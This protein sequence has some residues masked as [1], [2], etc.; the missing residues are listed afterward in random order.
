MKH[1]RLLLLCISM[2]LCAVSFQAFAAE[3]NPSFSIQKVIF[4][5]DGQM[6]LIVYVPPARE[7]TSSRL[8]LTLDGHPVSVSSIDS[9]NNSSYRTTWLFL[10][11]RSTIGATT[12]LKT[13][14]S[15]LIDL[16]EPGDNAGILVTGFGADQISLTNDPVNLKLLVET[17][18]LKRNTQETALN[19]TAATAIQYLNQYDQVKSRACLVL[20]SNGENK[21]EN[22]MTVTEL[23]DL[24]KSS[25]ITVYTY[26]FQD[27]SPQSALINRFE[28]LARLSCGGVATSFK[29]N[30][31][32]SQI[33]DAVA[34]VRDNE[35]RFCV[36]SCN[37][38]QEDLSGKELT[39]SFTDNGYS[40]TA[41][42]E[43]TAEQM[44]EYAEILSVIQ[45]SKSTPAPTSTLTPTPTSTP[46]PEPTSTPVPTSTPAPTLSPT[47]EN[48]EQPIGELISKLPLP[49]IGVAVVMVLILLILVVKMMKRPPNPD[50]DPNQDEAPVQDE[51]PVQDE[52]PVQN[53]VPV[54]EKK[55]ERHPLSKPLAHV[56]F[57][58]SRSGVQYQADMRNTLI[59]G[60]D[61]MRANLLLDCADTSI[62]GIHLRLTYIDGVMHAKDISRNGTFIGKVKIG[63]DAIL[64][65]GEQIK[66][67]NSEFIITWTPL[68]Q[69]R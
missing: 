31:K 7:L 61:P 45:D 24:I 37:P 52:A 63:D 54:Q 58:L 10:S 67:G 17:D 39:L 21:D 33:Q 60:R 42:I 50:V 48:T 69:N 14:V 56:V 3:G 40:M 13:L 18:L 22:G 20:I 68:S 59:V 46:T 62:S 5:K 36:I 2:M 23:Q 44:A 41:K 66:L 8:T 64:N 49:I 19:A 1:L 9:L 26:T 35:R 27:D 30:V 53:E 6:D 34:Q 55:P 15:N 38:A 65:N 51:V 57:T 16:M 25:P 29:E 28:S 47:P 4:E 32:E 11:D 12:K 43:L